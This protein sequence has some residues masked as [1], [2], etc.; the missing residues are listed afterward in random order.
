[1]FHF[2]GPERLHA[3]CLQACLVWWSAVSP[4]KPY[5]PL[6]ALIFVVGVAA[7]KAAFEDRKRHNED[8][9][10]NNSIAHV[11]QPDGAPQNPNPSC[12]EFWGAGTFV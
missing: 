9:L 4:F 10:L 8:D 12:F 2:R 5:G 1:M 6:I 11:V 7:I 3:V